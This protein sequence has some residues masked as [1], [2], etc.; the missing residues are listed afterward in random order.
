M[1]DVSA[2]RTRPSASPSPPARVHDAAG[3]ARPHP[4]PAASTKG[5]VLAVARLAGIMG[6]QAHAR[7][8]PALPSAGA[9]A[10]EVELA[11]DPRAAP[12]DITA[13]VPHHRPHRRRD[14]GAD[15]GR[16]GGAHDLRHVQGGRSRHAHRRA[17][18]CIHKSGG[19]SG[20]YEA[21]PMISVEEA[22]AAP[23]GAAQAARRRAGGAQPRR[24]AACSPRMWPRAAPSRPSPSRRWTAMPCARPMSRACRRRSRWSARCRRA[25]AYRRHGRRRRGGAHLHRRAA[26]RRRRRHRHPG[27]H[28][29]RRR[30]RDGAARARARA[31]MSARPG[32]I[33]ARARSGSRP[34]GASPRAI[35]AWP[36]R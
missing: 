9:D 34:G 1:V 21:T 28:R 31:A 22:R 25:S 8:H 36:R 7:S 35:S 11:C 33:S 6:G 3:D 14:G 19:K 27:R 29:A 2:P 18:G 17:S 4:S 5:D 10:V 15:R 32:S 12:V 26:A 24:S 13:T 16:G 20:T 30:R 23:A